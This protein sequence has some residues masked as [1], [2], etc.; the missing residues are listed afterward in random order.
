MFQGCIKLK[1][2]DL[3]NFNTTLDVNMDNMFF[4]CYDLMNLNFSN[5][6]IYDEYHTQNMFFCCRS[7]K[8]IDVGCNWNFSSDAFTGVGSASAPCTLVTDWPFSKSVLTGP[9]ASKVAGNSDY[10]TWCDGYFLCGDI[11]T[12]KR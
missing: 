10:Y 11:R 7:L 5:F 1:A 3:S 4:Q 9:I 8:K 2:L 12:N 6:I